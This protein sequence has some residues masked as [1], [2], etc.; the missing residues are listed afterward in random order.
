MNI[1]PQKIHKI[2]CLQKCTVLQSVLFKHGGILCIKDIKSKH[3]HVQKGVILN[4]VVQLFVKRF[5]FLRESL[6]AKLIRK[7]LF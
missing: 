7:L 1:V 3:N 5:E 2:V 4:N 6:A